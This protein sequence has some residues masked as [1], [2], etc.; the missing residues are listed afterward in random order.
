MSLR[1]ALDELMARDQVLV[2]TDFDGVIAPLVQTPDE[3]LPNPRAMAVLAD[4]ASRRGVHVAVVSGRARDD[5]A[6][7]LGE[8]AGAILVGEHGNDM[9]QV[10]Q[11]PHVLRE[12]RRFIHEMHDTMPEATVEDKQMSVTFHTRN[13]ESWRSGVA[14]R[15]IRDWVAGRRGIALLEGKEVFELTVATRTKGDA[16]R[17]LAQDVDGVAY[18]GDDLTDESVFEWLRP[19][20]VGIKVGEGETAAEYRVADVSGVVDVLEWMRSARVGVEA[21]SSDG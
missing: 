19:T 17:E 8:L 20:D 3:S 10:V 11:T 15:A 2:G 21:G 12:A 18:L 1:E 5:L 13:L 4:L 16:M 9:G 14:G 6:V 7:R